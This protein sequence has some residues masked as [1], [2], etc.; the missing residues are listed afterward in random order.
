MVAP[1]PRYGGVLAKTEPSFLTA[2]LTIPRTFRASSWWPPSLAAASA[3]GEMWHSEPDEENPR[4]KRT[5]VHHVSCKIFCFGFIMP[6]PR[7]GEIR[8]RFRTLVGAIE[9]LERGARAQS[10]WICDAAD[11]GGHHHC[12]YGGGARTGFGSYA[13]ERYRRNRHTRAAGHDGG[14][15][16]PADCRPGKE[17]K[18]ADSAKRS[19]RGRAGQ[20]PDSWTVGHAR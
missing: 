5:N 10:N 1:V 15:P 17:R 19:D 14:H 13:R 16:G 18:S 12:D 8:R 6:A 11:G 2:R 20:V 3:A 7:Q 9:T 4:W